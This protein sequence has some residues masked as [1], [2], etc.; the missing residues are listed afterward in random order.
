MLQY[1]RRKLIPLRNLVK[2]LDNDMVIISNVEFDVTYD[3]R[4]VEVI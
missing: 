3:C 4:R 1:S 2:W